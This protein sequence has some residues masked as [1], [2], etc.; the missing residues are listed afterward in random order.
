LN[1]CEQFVDDE[2]KE[3]EEAME[4]KRD[5]HTILF[6]L[7]A[8]VAVQRKD[9]DV[10][11]IAAYAY[12]DSITLFYTK[13]DLTKED[14]DHVQSLVRLVQN[15]AKDT[16]TTRLQFNERMFQLVVPYCSGKL[17]DRLN[18]LQSELKRKK[19]PT[20]TVPSSAE[21][22]IARYTSL[23]CDA[24]APQETKT[25][26][27]REAKRNSKSQNIYDGLIKTFESLQKEVCDRDLSKLSPSEIVA[28]AAHSYIVG[29]ASINLEI[30]ADSPLLVKIIRSAQKVGDYFRCATRLYRAIVQSHNT[31]RRFSKINVIAIDPPEPQYRSL[32]L[33][34]YHVL[35]CVWYRHVGGFLP[36]TRG[37]FMS[38]YAT[39]L[40]K[41][42]EWGEQKF[43]AH[44]EVTLITSLVEVHRM[45]PTVIGVSKSCCG[46]CTAFI[47]GVNNYRASRNYTTWEPP[48]SHGNHYNCQIPNV[49][50]GSLLAG[51]REVNDYIN[52]R[53]IGL[54][55]DCIPVNKTET[56]PQWSGS[57]S[58]ESPTASLYPLMSS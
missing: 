28:I 49:S 10:A 4:D 22:L 38:K 18:A 50:E 5:E 46:L 58:G 8:L 7:L 34:W 42:A 16:Q 6:F 35:E 36:I 26:S 56:P 44:A 31:R 3:F 13:N 14:K 1:R 43:V 15:A 47:S 12:K 48:G 25:A 32:Q 52:L 51:A 11:A 54:V 45:H 53:I 57:E 37:Q 33:D 20:E 30:V 41:Y 9:G 19:K 40:R 39:G 21:D 24:T 29:Y 55:R 17:F 23:K 2:A 27:D